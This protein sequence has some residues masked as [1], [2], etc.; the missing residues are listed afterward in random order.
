MRKSLFW[1]VPLAVLLCLFGALAALL[2]PRS[3]P[4]TKAS[5]E[6]IREGMTLAEVE[7]L[8]GRPPGDYST[9]PTRLI[10]KEWKSIEQVERDFGRPVLHWDGDEGVVWLIVDSGVVE[11]AGFVEGERVG[12]T[13]DLLGWRVDRLRRSVFGG[14]P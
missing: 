11:V 9:G 10:S 12:G 6:R 4:V 2:S 1:L 5:S 7:A 8:L 14:G 3:C 13:V